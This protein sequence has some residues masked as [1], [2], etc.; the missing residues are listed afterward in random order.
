MAPTTSKIQLNLMN[1]RKLGSGC[2]AVGCNLT[3]GTNA[4]SK[5]K[6]FRF[7]KE[8]RRRKAWITAVKREAWKPGKNSRICSTHFVSD[9]SIE[10]ER[11]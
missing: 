11:E 10:T 8:E 3:S 9:F 2:C 4:I 5:I 6:M 1:R 7:P